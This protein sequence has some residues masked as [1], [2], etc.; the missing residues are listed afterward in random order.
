MCLYAFSGNVEC[1]N[2]EEVVSDSS[3]IPED[4]FEKGH[5]RGHLDCRQIRGREISAIGPPI[6]PSRR[7]VVFL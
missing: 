1:V 5:S 7:Y 6:Q 2:Q 4:R 3:P